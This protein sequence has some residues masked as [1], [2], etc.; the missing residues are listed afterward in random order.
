MTS[1][2]PNYLKNRNYARAFPWEANYVPVRYEVPII[3]VLTRIILVPDPNVHTGQT[4]R[5][6]G[7]VD[8]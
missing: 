8:M 5:S 2:K 3:G 6:R 1:K 7:R 4:R